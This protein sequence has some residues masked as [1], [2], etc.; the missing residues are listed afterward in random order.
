VAENTLRAVDKDTDLELA[1]WYYQHSQVFVSEIHACWKDERKPRKKFGHITKCTEKTLES[2]L[3]AKKRA[4][5]DYVES[6][7]EDDE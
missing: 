2:M 6:V 7:L 3:K 4:V 5:W 1:D